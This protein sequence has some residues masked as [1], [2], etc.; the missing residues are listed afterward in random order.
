MASG[1]FASYASVGRRVGHA[2]IM[3]RVLGSRPLNLEAT[4]R[5][6]V[7]D[8][9]L[10][11]KWLTTRQ[12]V[13]TVLTIAGLI[14][15]IGFGVFQTNRANLLAA[16]HATVSQPREQLV[17]ADKSSRASENQN[18]D[19]SKVVGIATLVILLV[20]SLIFARQASLMRRQADIY[21]RQAN[22]MSGQLHAT[23]VAAD[24][25]KAS[26]EAGTAQATAAKE[27]VEVARK[28]LIE[29]RRPY[30]LIECTK[31]SVAEISE[32]V[33]SP[34][35]FDYVVTN[36]GDG[37]ALIQSY[38]EAVVICPAPP[39]QSDLNAVAAAPAKDIIAKAS[40]I[41]RTSQ[42]EARHMSAENYN[43]LRRRTTRAF[44]IGQVTYQDVFYETYLT[45]FCFEANRLGNI[46]VAGE[47]DINART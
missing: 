46:Y 10:R 33:D 32:G 43:E 7:G 4:G 1:L 11:V 19:V 45:K 16:R 6:R 31:S 34:L 17:Q 26:A 14:G 2:S 47:R 20:Q 3:W 36:F 13:R 35:S 12:T 28:A 5:S 41:C 23:K 15:L 24:A 39:N 18:D 25:A 30:I 42:A 44:I 37:P 21:D 40:S 38:W 22:L 29:G 27:Q 8:S 9:A